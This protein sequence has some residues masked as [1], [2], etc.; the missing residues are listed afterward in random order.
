MDKEPQSWQPASADVPNM[1]SIEEYVASS[2]GSIY[3]GGDEPLAVDMTDLQVVIPDDILS[4]PDGT[5]LPSNV[6]RRFNI[7][8]ATIGSTIDFLL[9]MWTGDNNAPNQDMI[10]YVTDGQYEFNALMMRPLYEAGD[11][12]DSFS[13]MAKSM[14]NYIRAISNV[15]EPGRT[16]RWVTHIRVRWGFIVL[17]VLL[18]I[19]AC[20]FTLLSIMETR[21]LGLP[22]WKE[23]AMPMMTY[24]LDGK[25]RAKLRETEQRGRHGARKML[26][27]MEDD[28][29]GLEL[30]S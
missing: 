3:W 14:T 6:T 22:A 19:S 1:S 2:N 23:D 11:P 27:K 8:Q 12:Q 25:T 15:T 18:F 16:L 5:T 4:L 29:D 7:T 30:K 13:H 28:G 21:R 24:G 26:V 17:P 20:A 10:Y 9:S